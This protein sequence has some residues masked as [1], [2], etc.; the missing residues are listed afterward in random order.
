MVVKKQRTVVTGPSTPSAP[1]IGSRTNSTQALPKSSHKPTTAQPT[2]TTTKSNLSKSI[3]LNNNTKKN[4][5]YK[6]HRKDSLISHFFDYL[7]ILFL[8]TFTL[9]TYNQCSSLENSLQ[10][11]LC[12]SLYTYK[13]HIV[14]P[15]ILPGLSY[16]YETV[17]SH[18]TVNQLQ[19]QLQ[20]HVERVKPHAQRAVRLT[21]HYS[22]LVYGRVIL[23]T[24][25]NRVLPF[26]KSAWG[27]GKRGYY[28]LL[29][30][31]IQPHLAKLEPYTSQITTY[32]KKAYTQLHPRLL[33]FAE[34]T[35]TFWVHTRHYGSILFN[36]ANR[37][38][39]ILRP[40]LITVA[41][42]LQTGVGV[43][44]GKTK[45]LVVQG[46]ETYVGPHLNTISEKVIELSGKPKGNGNGRTAT[47]SYTYRVKG[48]E[49][50]GEETKA[51]V[52]E[53]TASVN[54]STATARSKVS[55]TAEEAIQAPVETAAAPEVP[56]EPSVPVASVTSSS[57]SSVETEELASASS[58]IADRAS[59]ES[60]KA[61]LVEEIES[62]IAAVTASSAKA[63]IT[64]TST[65]AEEAVPTTE[66][67]QLASAASVIAS[68]NPEE[69]SVVEE[70][71]A[72]AMS[73]ASAVSEEE[74][75]DS[76][77]ADLG[78][79]DDQHNANKKDDDDLDSFL[80]DL[81]LDESGTARGQPSQ[82]DSEQSKQEQPQ[83]QTEQSQRQQETPEER[84]IRVSIKRAEIENRHL[85]WEDK[86]IELVEDSERDLIEFLS[87]FRGVAGRLVSGK[88]PD[89]DL[90]STLDMRV[91]LTN[92]NQIDGIPIGGL[93]SSLE[94]EGERLLSGVEGW[95]KR[96]KATPPSG[97]EKTR[98]AKSDKLDQLIKKV[99]ERFDEK[100]SEMQGRVHQWYVGVR[101]VESQECL[102]VA[103][104]IRTLA[105]EAQSDLGMDYAWLE[106]V[107]YHDWQRYHDL[108][109]VY[110]YFDKLVRHMQNPEQN[111]MP[112]LDEVPGAFSGKLHL[113]ALG[114]DVDYPVQGDGG[115]DAAH[116]TQTSSNK[117]DEKAAGTEADAKE[118]GKDEIVL[119]LDALAQELE[120]LV[121][122]WG[123]RAKEVEGRGRTAIF[124]EEEKVEEEK[125][126]E[127]ANEK[128][129]Q[130][131]GSEEPVKILPIEP[132]P[133]KEEI[134]G[135]PQVPIIGKSK[136]Q[137]EQA[138]K[139]AGYGAKDEL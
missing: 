53:A 78:V 21:S 39:I 123:W 92:L 76:F 124:G 50:V 5:K 3:T 40:Y 100:V 116:G 114:T 27:A 9:Y 87:A 60:V 93:I 120:L 131:E 68:R 139:V 107:N 23:P 136:E 91:D 70:I 47:G 35:H 42:K 8:S 112:G 128:V 71:K 138:M 88:T 133:G 74:D 56:E 90:L 7:L 127:S 130:V 111:P 13:T 37:V 81:G 22:R 49:G 67:E 105:D 121:L 29:H 102:Q 34:H 132:A 94:K 82:T 69:S 2:T 95:V 44:Y 33:H 45:P 10:N 65:S 62:S 98:K 28:G 115:D 135:A 97:D 103:K 1:T 85:V 118:D 119:A 137:I 64:P 104:Q 48:D 99:K 14:D 86:L 59:S 24:W 19:Q 36:Y 51:S 66:I 106:N 20:P 54:S 61:S 89:K 17:T 77:L 125:K 83:E 108:I 72:S 63:S 57:P 58:V 75:V 4:Q 129:E 55:T 134:G 101:D 38:Y 15:Y 96:E 43:A 122:G 41:E 73:V 16:T 26:S 12:K 31:H 6:K 109:R 110:E 32:S 113:V 84:E 80:S 117:V 18:P 52:E 30:P 11:P 25:N 79:Q 126:V 46:W